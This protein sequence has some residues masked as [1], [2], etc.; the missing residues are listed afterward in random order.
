MKLLGYIRVSSDDQAAN[1]HSLEAQEQ[2]I[3]AYC[4]LYGHE[5]VGVVVEPGHS[6]FKTSI[7]TRPGGAELFARLKK[8]EAEGF[9]VTRLERAF[10]RMA[11][12]EDL[13]PKLRKGTISLLSIAEHIDTS[14]PAGR[15][16]FRMVVGFAEYDSDV[17]ADRN[18]EV[19]KHLLQ[20]GKVYGPVSYGLTKV[21]G[22]KVEDP[23]TGKE[24][25]VG[26]YLRKDPKVW[27][28]REEVVRLVGQGMTQ[29]GVCKT[30]QA[31]GI[32][33]PSGKNRWAPSTVKE[34]CDNHHK[35]QHIPFAD[36]AHE[37]QV[38]KVASSPTLPGQ[39]APAFFEGA[40]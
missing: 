14:T 17:K 12:A 6:A 16:M 11:D 33:T 28:L 8:G 21:G 27:P 31:K 20:Q 29:R 2:R 10:R 22:K 30:M 38:S 32:K 25:R 1:G 19:A 39:S 24:K 4:D 18:K 37:A 26:G 7:F 13:M 23:K 3:R 34:I 9:I 5:L 35:Y 36:A 40:N 15:L